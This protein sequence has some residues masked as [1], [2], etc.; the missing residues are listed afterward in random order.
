LC[1][2][3]SSQIILDNTA[4]LDATNAVAMD[5]DADVIAPADDVIPTGKN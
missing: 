4:A 1:D 5:T 2:A 3:G